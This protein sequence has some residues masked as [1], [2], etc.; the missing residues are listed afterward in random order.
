MTC[1]STSPF[2]RFRALLA[3][4]LITLLAGSGCGKKEEEAKKTTEVEQLEIQPVELREGDREAFEEFALF[5]EAELNAGNYN[6][7]SDRFSMDHAVDYLFKDMN[8][9]AADLRGFREEFRDNLARGF[10]INFGESSVKFLEFRPGDGRPK[11]LFRVIGANSALSYFDLYVIRDSAGEVQIADMYNYVAGEMVL[12]SVRR[13]MLAVLSLRDRTLLSRLTN[14]DADLAKHAATVAELNQLRQEG[15]FEAAYAKLKELPDSIRSE[16]PTMIIEIMIASELDESIYLGAMENFQATFP[17][18]PSV[19]MVMLDYYFLNEDYAMVRESVASLR[20]AV[21][22]PYL[23]YYDVLSYV[24]EENYA[25]ARSSAEAYLAED[26]GAEYALWSSVE[27]ALSEPDHAELATLLTR[28]E[29]E[30]G[31]DLRP[32]VES[33]ANYAAFCESPEGKAWMAAGGTPR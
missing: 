25:A 17:G 9:S 18:D 27:V 4:V 5:L 7:L 26:P 3:A 32:S 31:Y 6:A 28:L 20:E 24:A 13:M 1:S 10:R 30:H 19:P 23:Y 22:D 12:Q 11:L 33:N 8:V 29:A 21:N 16:K 15:N 14:R 2:A